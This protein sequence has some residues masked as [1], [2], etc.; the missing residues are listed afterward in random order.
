MSEIDNLEIRVTSSADDATNHINTLASAMDR[1]KG[2]ANAVKTAAGVIEDS[3]EHVAASTETATKGVRRLPS[4]LAEASKTFKASGSGIK[5]FANAIKNALLPMG[6]FAKNALGAVTGLFRSIGRIAFYRSIRAL[7]KDIVQSFKDLY[8]YSKNAGTGFASSMDKITTSLKYF[9]NSIAAMVSPLIN[10][11]APVIDVIIDKVVELLNWFN[12]LFSALSG[13]D[14]YTVA[15]K[16][17]VTWDSTFDKST[18]SARKTAN[19]IKRTILGFDEINKLT[20]PNEASTSGGSGSSPYSDNYNMMF[21][22]R[23]VGSGFSDFGKAIE[24]AME[25]TVSRLWMILSGAFLVLGGILLFSGANPA[26]GIGLMING[27]IGLAKTLSPHWGALKEYMEGPL[28]TLTTMLSLATLVLGFVAISAGRIPLGIG[29]VVS[30]AFGLATNIPARWNRLQEY[31]EGP[32]GALTEILSAAFLVLGFVALAA[33]R[34]PLGVGLIVSGAFGL[35]STVP[36]RWNRLQEYLEGPVGLLTEILSG[37]SLVLG[38]VALA[39]GRVPLGV[40]LIVSG[41]LGLTATV[42]ARW[43]RLNKYV[44]DPLQALTEVLSGI[45]LVL[46]FV[47]LAA[48]RVPLGVGLIVTGAFGLGKS[49]PARWD[50]L[51]GYMEGPLG[52]L[53]EFLSGASLVLGFIAFAT[54]NV[55]LGAGLVAA[56]AAGLGMSAG[57]VDWDALGKDISDAWEKIKENTSQ[58]WEK[59]KSSVSET[60]G[61]L[62]ANATIA[63]TTIK[64]KVKNAWDRSVEWTSDKWESIKSTVVDKW[65]T[66]KASATT[67]FSNIKSK[68]QTAWDTLSTNTS[69]KWESIKGTATGIWDNL[70]GNAS[71]TF[72]DIK[73][74][75]TDSW[76]KVK[77]AL[78]TFT[79]WIN[80]TFSGG[81][82]NAWNNIVN[83]FGTIFGGIKEAAKTPINAVIGFINML[84]GKVETAV[85]RIRRGISNTIKIDIPPVD[86]GVF[87]TT[88]RIYWKP[89]D[90]QDVTFNRIHELAKG[91]ILNSAA[92]IAPN[93]MAGEAGREA[94]LPLENN[95]EWM[96]MLANRI[97]DINQDRANS[98]A[99]NGMAIMQAMLNEMRSIL[100]E[101]RRLNDKEFTAEVTSSSVQRAMNR[102]NRRAGV[103][104]MAVGPT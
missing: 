74:F 20:K 67:T 78:D 37:A 104:V 25:N 80:D 102:T 39:A 10:A 19:E 96:D 28:G 9:H 73:D 18:K 5:A 89:L 4:A 38:F 23:K 86:L 62:K 11:I 16:V 41:A 21:E 84:I 56:G 17:A 77:G 71:S 2:K 48:G 49:I 7:L 83:L 97:Y 54:G 29:L 14:T 31:M 76:D 64:G 34:I 94:V 98:T 92:M 68:V 100:A 79:K 30:G 52:A 91:G 50:R 75:V 43:D 26:L 27:A 90:L 69:E 66:M 70:K 95:T 60:W 47:A 87:G 36:A 51:N 12:Q 101:T 93:V 103:T 8:G 58:A 63:F 6:Q 45:S 44:E 82:E 22:Q 81:W 53:T 35:A 46:G 13:A 33:G 1:F 88:P 3:M 42:A 99:D 57:K 55:L 59:I 72:G 15:K 61:V 85:N 24:S 40:G 65:G 32:I